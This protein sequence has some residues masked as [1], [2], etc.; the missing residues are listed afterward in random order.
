MS[1]TKNIR[2]IIFICLW[3]LAGAAFVV[4]LCL[5]L[6]GPATADAPLTQGFEDGA[7]GWT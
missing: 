3:I 7:P 2:R 1:I 6:S 4:L 5:V